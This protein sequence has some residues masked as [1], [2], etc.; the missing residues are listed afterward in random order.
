VPKQGQRQV[1]ETSKRQEDRQKQA[2]QGGSTRIARPT[3]GRSGSDT[4][5]D[6]GGS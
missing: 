6:K 3:S 4:N 5:K 2:A 1:T